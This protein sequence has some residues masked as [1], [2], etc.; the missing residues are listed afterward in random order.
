MSL[1][2]QRLKT[3]VTTRFS[4]AA[5]SN[6][7]VYLLGSDGLKKIDMVASDS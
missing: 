6:G 5:L 7:C 2:A 4:I 1:C 3:G